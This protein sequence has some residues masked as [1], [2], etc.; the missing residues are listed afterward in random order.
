MNID[1]IND[2]MNHPW[3]M[4]EVHELGKYFESRGLTPFEGAWVMSRLI[5]IALS[6]LVTETP[7]QEGE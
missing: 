1:E 7:K 2:R 6:S 5:P 4:E 3:L